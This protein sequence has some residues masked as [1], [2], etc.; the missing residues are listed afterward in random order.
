MDSGV[1]DL[2]NVGWRVHWV[3]KAELD[4]VSEPHDWVLADLLLPWGKNFDC[5]DQ[6]ECNNVNELNE[7]VEN[8]SNNKEW[9]SN[10]DLKLVLNIVDPQHLEDSMSFFALPVVVRS[11]LGNAVVKTLFIKFIEIG[12]EH[13]TG[14]D[15]KEE[16]PQEEHSEP[17]GSSGSCHAF[18]ENE[19]KVSGDNK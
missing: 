3:E 17:E 9:E 11:G 10:K 15:S 8:S 19:L 1:L 5:E 16:V 4:S 18:E 14:G 2:E 6:W 13:E 7:A 12:V